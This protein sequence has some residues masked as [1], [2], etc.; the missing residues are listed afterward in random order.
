GKTM[1]LT[2]ERVELRGPIGLDEHGI[3]PTGRVYWNPSTSTLYLHAL[4]LGDARLAEG[5][6][7]VVDTGRHTGR[8]PKDKFVVREPESEKRIWWDDVNQEIGE[9]HFGG[10]R[11]KAGSYLERLHPYVCHPL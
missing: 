5:G 1:A 3:F 6:P 2:P 4:L 7:L 11:A 8:S 10:L 9:E